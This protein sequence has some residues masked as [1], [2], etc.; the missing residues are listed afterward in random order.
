M[1]A[2]AHRTSPVT[3]APLR[4]AVD[5]QEHARIVAEFA[6]AVTRLDQTTRR[7]AFVGLSEDRHLVER[8]DE[9][10]KRVRG[11]FGS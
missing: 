4:V 5:P 6:V 10:V 3:A 7:L 8:N 2:Q 1:T 9:F 11:R